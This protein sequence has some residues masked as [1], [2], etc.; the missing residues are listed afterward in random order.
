M[1]LE[2]LAEVSGFALRAYG[3]ADGEAGLEEVFHDPYGDVAVC[4]S[5]ENL[6]RVDGGHVER[7]LV[8]SRL[9]G[10]VLGRGGTFPA[11]IIS[12]RTLSSSVESR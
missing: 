6:P 1:C 5:D 10:F 3:A 12:R 11:F 4:A 2:K 7:I 9:G 8:Q